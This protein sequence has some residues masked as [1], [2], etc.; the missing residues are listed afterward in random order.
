[1]SIDA[2][3]S[4]I[5]AKSASLAERIHSRLGKDTPVTTDDECSAQHY[6]DLWCN[7]AADGNWENFQKR[8]RWD[9]LDSDAIQLI[10]ASNHVVPMDEPMWLETMRAILQRVK[11]Y[12]PDQHKSPPLDAQK[13][14]PFQDLLL[15]ICQ[16]AREKI[17]TTA[18]SN[19][20]A[21]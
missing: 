3:L 12:R 7:T 14:L 10:F 6:I 1:M 11:T 20:S 19:W 4:E 9:G 2:V 21:R 13:P 8:L 17:A 5:L 15:P 18:R 16:L